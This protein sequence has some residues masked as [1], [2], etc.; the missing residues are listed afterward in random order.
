M[1]ARIGT[2]GWAIGKASGGAFPFEGSNLERYSRVLSV[3]EIN[4]SFHRSHRAAT[5]ERWRDSVPTDFRFSA[6]VPKAITH[7][8]KLIGCDELISQFVAEAELL[9]DRLAVLLVQLPPKLSFDVHL[10]DRFFHRLRASTAASIVVEPRHASWFDVP[11]EALLNKLH[12]ARAAADPAI[13]P[14]A[15]RPGGWRELTYW[16]LHGSPIKYRSSY[17]DRLPSYARALLETSE[18]TTESWCI[19]DNT[20]SS[21]AISDALQLET[22]VRGRI[23]PASACRRR[24][25]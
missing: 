17:Q 23:T 2:A 8:H 11:A 3:T 25:G 12:V 10:A 20:A 9:A 22:C 21:A 24:Q 1:R 7:K 14:S 18:Q 6:K 19:F 13:C 4:S 16:R 15:A 5:W